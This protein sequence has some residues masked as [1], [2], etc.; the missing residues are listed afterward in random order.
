MALDN[1]APNKDFFMIS[2]QSKIY[3]IRFK[4]DNSHM[5]IARAIY[6]WILKANTHI[7]SRCF[8]SVNF[9]FQHPTEKSF[10]GFISFKC[11]RQLISDHITVSSKHR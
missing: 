5:A 4:A 6:F 10:Y 9:S 1:F 3:V 8:K 11:A 2:Y 7:A